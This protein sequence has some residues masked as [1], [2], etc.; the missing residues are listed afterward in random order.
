MITNWWIG[1]ACIGTL[2]LF[3]CDADIAPPQS[4]DKVD[5]PFPEPVHRVAVLA[6]DMSDLSENDMHQRTSPSGRMYYSA[7]VTVN[8]SLQSCL[9]FYVTVKGKKFGSLTISYN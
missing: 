3:S 4:L 9:E 2:E 1:D 5:A 8:I 6:Y 7:K